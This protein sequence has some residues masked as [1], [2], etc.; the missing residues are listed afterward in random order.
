[1]PHVIDQSPKTLRVG[2]FSLMSKK[3]LLFF[4]N[5]NN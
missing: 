2:L 4:K 1:V 3:K 5:Y